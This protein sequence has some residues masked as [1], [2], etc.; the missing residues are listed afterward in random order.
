MYQRILV[1]VSSGPA[2]ECGAR[3]A[4][5][6]ARVS[7][8][9]LRFIHVVGKSASGR[10]RSGF[11]GTIDEYLALLEALDRECAVI[12]AGLRELAEAAGVNFDVVLRSTSDGTPCEWVVAEALGWR[13]D[14]IVMGA[15]PAGGVGL[16]PGSHGARILQ[17]SP[18]PVMVISPRVCH[19]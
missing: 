17:S 15:E 16:R 9:S 19:S 13:A 2:S 18:V 1:P 4:I 10:E 3:E 7:G 6:L 8:A 11:A 14:L 5:R 12:A